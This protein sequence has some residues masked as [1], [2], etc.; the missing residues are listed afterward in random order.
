[1]NSSS[2]GFQLEE[3][4]LKFFREEIQANRFFAR[5]E[6]CKL[7]HRKGYH[8][9]DR[10]SNIVFDIA[11]EIYLPAA[12]DPSVICL[13]ECKNYSH[14]VPVDDIEEF[15]TKLQQVAAARAKGIV[16]AANAFQRGAIEFARSK[17]IGLVR[18]FPSA[19]FKWVLHR[20]PSTFQMARTHSR[21]SIIMNGLTQQSYRSDRFDYF[22]ACGDVFTHSVNDFLVGLIS[23]DSKGR[24]LLERIQ[25]SALT[26]MGVRFVTTAAL[27]QQ[28]REVH[29]QIGYVSGPVSLQ[30][31]SEW[32]G[33]VDTLSVV[34]GALAT[35]EDTLRGVLGRISFDPAEI[36]VFA[37]PTGGLRQR[38]TWAHELAHLLLGHSEYMSSECVDAVDVDREEFREL[39]FDEIA[40]L[41]WQ[42]NYFA[43]C[44][45]LP[46]DAFIATT[47][48]AA[49]DL[50]LRDRGH[51][52]IYFDHQP[53]NTRNYYLLTSTLMK[54]FE[55]SRTAIRLRLKTLGFLNE[56]AG[57]TR[58]YENG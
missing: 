58:P 56:G 26:V 55:A 39:G 6:C 13:I 8:S 45:L 28:C 48:K 37:D 24:G 19:Q 38:F 16:V 27:E 10:R 36:I 15:F 47:L 4:V 20:S 53:V 29:R 9:R 21:D 52:L 46:K 23:T 35:E 41:E 30:A 43:S 25:S 32:R 57:G 11:L 40:R 3:R 18:A 5:P 49:R 14:P 50:E 44:L 22:C 54:R 17:G 2:A 1:M 34:I 31:V 7:F 33:K 42:A 51:G 12:Q